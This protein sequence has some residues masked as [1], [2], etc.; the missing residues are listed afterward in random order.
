MITKEIAEILNGI[1][2]CFG[3]SDD[4]ME[5]RGAIDDEA[6]CYDGGLVYF[7][8]SGELSSECND[9][10]CP[11]F[12]KTKENA[13]KIKAIWGAGGYAWTYETDIP[14]ETFEMVDDGC[15]YCRGVVFSIDDVV[16]G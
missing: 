11:Y 9:D 15:E 14:H 6:G 10:D 2:Y 5:F 12:E 1:E 4:L 16:E 8:R 7:N 13:S 3:A